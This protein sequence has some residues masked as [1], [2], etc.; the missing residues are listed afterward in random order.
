ML[1]EG[2]TK[3]AIHSLIASSEKE[4]ECAVK[5]LLEFSS[6]EVCCI[7][8]ASEKGALVLLSSMEGNLDHPALSNLAEEVLKRIENISEN[9]QHLAAAGRF[10]PLLRQLFEGRLY[11]RYWLHFLQ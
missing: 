2:T 11:T 1:E 7:K 3:L 6:D 4:R 9:I 8:I 10:E 5:L